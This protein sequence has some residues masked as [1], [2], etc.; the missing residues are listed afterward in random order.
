MIQVESAKALDHLEELVTIEG[1]A[2][3]FVGPWDLAAS[4]GHLGDPHHPDVVKAI[5]STIARIVQSGKAAGIVTPDVN[6][7][8]SYI[9]QGVTFCA[10]GI[11]AMMLAQS[12]RALA[13]TFKI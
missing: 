13:R 3:I 1:V 6:L 9:K 7:A 4:L 11:D 5:E 12:S 8:H 10:V 2:G